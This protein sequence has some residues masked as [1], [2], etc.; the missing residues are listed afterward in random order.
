LGTASDRIR[1]AFQGELFIVPLVN[2]PLRPINEGRILHD[3]FARIRNIPDLEVAVHRVQLQGKITQEEKDRFLELIKQSLDDPQ[4]SKWFNDDW[5]V[6]NE[7]EIILPGGMIKRPDRVMIKTGQTVVIDYKFGKNT[8]A[9][10]EQQ[11]KEYARFMEDMG[12]MNV[13]AFVWYVR[14]G[15]VVSCR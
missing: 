1:I 10:Y 15:K 12:Y 9:V 7:A 3:I 2:K 14:L 5:T 8:E 13:E 6:L 4:V 11:V